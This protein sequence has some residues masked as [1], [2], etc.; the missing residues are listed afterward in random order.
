ME[1]GIVLPIILI[2]VSVVVTF[3]LAKAIR[4]FVL[5]SRFDG[6]PALPLVG[7]AHEF[8]SDQREFFVDMTTLMEE[9]RARSGG[10]LKMWLGPVP[11]LTLYKAKHVEVI[12]NNSRH[13][14]KGYLYKFLEPWLGLGLLTS[15]GQKWF[16]RRKMLTPTFHFSILQ[17]FMDVF[18]EQSMIL[19]K[20]LE[21]FAEK[22]ETVN[23]FP[24]VAYCVLD[25]ICITAMGR[26]SNAQENSE[27]EYVKAVGRMSELVTIRGKNPLL[28]P[29]FIFDKIKTGKEHKETLKIL[30][31]VTNK[32]IQERLKESPK[33]TNTDDDD[34]DVVARTR[35]RIAF[36]DLLLQM[37]REDASFTLG[38]IREEVDTFMF[39]G[40]DTTAAA[41]GWAILLIGH[42]P[43]VQ[44][45]LHMEI[46][47]VFGDSMRPVT[48][49]DLSRLQYLTCV[50][51][52]TLR[53]I[54]SVPSIFRKLDED[55]MLDGKVVPKETLVALS[56]YGLHQDPD[57]FPNPERFD[58][59]R[60]L[61]VNAEERHPYAYVPFS[62]G[63]RNCIGQKF[64]MME[65]KIILASI[66]RRFSIKSIQTI[67]EAKPAGQLILRPAEGN[68]LV[69]LSRRK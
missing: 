28:W 22:S 30:H 54:P 8:K 25:I 20:K 27:N 15:W 13:I 51:K 2:L 44:A 7:N 26:S 68:M 58:P 34:V 33:D 19:V 45:R 6:P 11:S 63:P 62:A 64:A 37:H 5:I 10:L 14:K 35:K 48:S 38:D 4:I 29:D 43:D 31:G 17:S 66:L 1:Y 56:I 55:I 32:M 57:E 21:K 60:F 65:D 52:E 47:E 61:P 9:Y 69:N 46:D 3:L 12:L 39:E 50:V 53:L 40:H 41:A 23:I 24:L 16:H 49:D 36:L 42:H 18:N 67:D 59:D